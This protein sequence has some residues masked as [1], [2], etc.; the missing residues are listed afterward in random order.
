MANFAR[1]DENSVVVDL[2]KIDNKNTV[3]QDGVETESIGKSYLEKMYGVSGWVQTSF[4]KSFR[5]NYATIGGTYNA[6]LDMFL[7]IK[8]FDSWIVD[9]STGEWVSPVSKPDD[10]KYTWNE[11]SKTWDLAED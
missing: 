5:K 11:T 9:K 6:D 3:D 4:N 8:P 10:N 2:V 7:N 1:I